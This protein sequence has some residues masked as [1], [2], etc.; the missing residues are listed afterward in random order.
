MEEVTRGQKWALAFALGCLPCT[1]AFLLGLIPILGAAIFA[2]H[3]A[4][5]AGAVVL[6]GGL[7][8]AALRRRVSCRLPE[9]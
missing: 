3:F 1:A 2:T 6:A 7:L 5:V 9:A 8:F 4:I